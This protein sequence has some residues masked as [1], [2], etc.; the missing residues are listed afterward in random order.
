MKFLLVLSMLFSVAAYGQKKP[1]IISELNDSVY[2]VTTYG[3]SD[4]QRYPANCMYVLT[5]NGAVL[6]DAPWDSTQVLPLIDSIQA[7]HHQSVVLC[8]ATHH[9]ADRTGGFNLLKELDIPTY[10]SAL[11]KHYCVQKGEAVPENT[12]AG[13]TT[14]EIGSVTFETYFPGA[15]HAPDNIVIWFPKWEILYGGCFVK[16]TESKNLGNIA[17]ADL[18]AW[19]EGIKKVMK[20]YKRPGYIIPGHMD[21]MSEKSLQHTL[22][23]LEAKH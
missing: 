4:N 6:I 18:K 2:I 14:F 7:R 1:L 10:T 20:R 23:L 22:K 15:G 17:D 21:W 9:H 5:S 8:I 19:E 12:F 3:M 11:T 16:S 13:D